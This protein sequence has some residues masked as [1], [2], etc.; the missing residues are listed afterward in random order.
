MSNTATAPAES[1]ATVAKPATP[2]DPSEHI[3][4][5]V[6]HAKRTYRKALAIWDSFGRDRLGGKN[7]PDL[8][9]FITYAKIGLWEA[10]ATYDPAKGMA[11][12][13]WASRLILQQ[14][15]RAWNDFQQNL[16]QELKALPLN[17]PAFQDD[18]DNS[19]ATPSNARNIDDAAEGWP[20][21]YRSWTADKQLDLKW[22]LDDFYENV[23]RLPRKT[24]A[25]ITRRFGLNGSGTRGAMSRQAVAKDLHIPEDRVR[26]LEGVAL[27]KLDDRL[28]C[29][30]QLS[31]SLRPSGRRAAKPKGKHIGSDS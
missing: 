9:D 10:A 1:E 6:Y 27:R 20:R 23:Q 30:A 13:S 26:W 16:Q 14:L 25:V 29:G 2:I 15:E 24:K 7:F 11:F 31:E 4:L 19:E 12:A 17:A 22:A 5:A 3:G 18:P 21:N 28:V 8:Q